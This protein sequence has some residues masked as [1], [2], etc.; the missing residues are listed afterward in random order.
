MIGFIAPFAGSADKISSSDG[1]LLCDGRALSRHDFQT[2]FDVIGTLHG[3]GD[4]VNTFNLPDYRGYFLR[5]TANGTNADPD[6]SVR[7]PS[8]P[9]GAAGDEVGSQQEYKTAMPRAPFA[10]EEHK[11]HS[12]GDPTWNGGPGT[13]E[14]ATLHRGPGGH[15]YRPQ[16][17]PTTWD[18]IHSHTINGGD[19]ETRPKNKAVHW[20]IKVR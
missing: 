14:L 11:G 20:L 19:I 1:W 7:Q 18:G 10:N 8:A 12:H 15:D 3:A 17:A 9:G 6:R 5:G 16:S 13:F 4:G 2:L